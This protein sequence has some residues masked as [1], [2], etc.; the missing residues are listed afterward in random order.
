[1]KYPQLE[2]IP[3]KQVQATDNAGGAAIATV[4]MRRKILS[5]WDQKAGFLHVSPRTAEDTLQ[6]TD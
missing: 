5:R 6:G 3:E 4:S 1:M 2:L